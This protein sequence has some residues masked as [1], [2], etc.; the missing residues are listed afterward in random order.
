V[1]LPPTSAVPPH[2]QAIAGAVPLGQPPFGTP[3]PESSVA[4]ETGAPTHETAPAENPAAVWGVPGSAAWTR[5]EPAPDAAAAANLQVSKPGADLGA[6]AVAGA[7]AAAAWAPEQVAKDVDPAVAEAS[8]ANPAEDWRAE[9]VAKDA[10]VEQPVVADVSVAPGENQL[11]KDA[12]SDLPVGADVPAV[13]DSADGP[14]PSDSPSDPGVRPEPEPEPQPATQIH[15]TSPA[16]VQWQTT[17][18]LA[19]EQLW[20]TLLEVIDPADSVLT[21]AGYRLES[22]ERAVLVRTAMANH[23]PAPHDALPDHYLVLRTATGAILTKAPMGVGSHPAY[24]VGVAPGGQADGW[25]VFLIPADT[26]L[27][28]VVWSVRPDLADRTL[29]WRV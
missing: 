5:S 13:G 7:A 3:P 12:G 26:V 11:A 8:A 4:A 16:Q 17:I 29:S 6:E 9:Q 23:G 20:V 22:G 1:V 10:P 25:T 18:G 14:A 15:A 27:T 24:R 21:D 2:E 19:G 28:D